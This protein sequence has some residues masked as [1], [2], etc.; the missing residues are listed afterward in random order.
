MKEITKIQ[1]GEKSM[2]RSIVSFSKKLRVN[3]TE[4]L[5]HHAGKKVKMKMGENPKTRERERERE[6]EYYN[7][8]I[9]KKKRAERN[10]IWK[11]AR[12]CGKNWREIMQN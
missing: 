7:N 8:V 1:F 5:R 12:A 11:A 9:Q 4:Q 10:E 2:N 3:Q 6:R